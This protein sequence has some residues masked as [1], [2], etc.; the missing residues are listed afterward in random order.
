MQAW[1]PTAAKS[2]QSRI[3][4]RL[5]LIGRDGVLAT[6][7]KSTLRPALACKYTGVVSQAIII[8]G[9]H[10]SGTSLVSNWLQSAGVN[11]GDRLLEPNVANPR[12]YFEDVDFYS[13][14]EQLLHEHG[15]TYLH[16]DPG[17]V[18]APT[19]TAVAGAR[20]LLDRRA[21]RP[22]WGWKDPRTSLFLNFWH[23]LL[24][25]ARYLFV[26]RHPLNVLLSL[27]RRGEFDNHPCPISGVDAWQRYNSRISKFYD[28][29]PGQ[30]VLIHIDGVVCRFEHLAEQLQQKLDLPIRL[31]AAAWKQIFHADELRS[32]AYPPAALAVLEKVAPGIHTLYQQL[33]AQADIPA[34]AETRDT[35]Q[36]VAPSLAALV[37]FA[38]ELPTPLSM[39]VRHGVLHL[40][41]SLLAPEP[42][43]KMLG[44]SG[45]QA[46]GAQKLIDWLWMKVRQ[47]EGTI[48]EQ[49]ANL[50]AKQ[51]DLD[52]QARQVQALSAELDRIYRTRTWKMLQA[53]GVIRTD[54]KKHLAA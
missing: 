8:T 33:E 38:G 50:Q 7:S 28:E 32:A 39:P 40:L 19:P 5:P 29:H 37:Q 41:V 6:A 26:Y 30:C 54:N 45:E 3:S 51:Q 23:D 42:T 1:A 35:G 4:A 14:H 12:G 21:D 16:V 49:Q 24:P 9:M 46:R 20:Q 13:Y 36:V 43:E 25:D 48:S 15:Q 18:F 2:R 34:P 47:L 17:F 44:R 27:L 53:I 22:L 11:I 31:D 10:R 52:S